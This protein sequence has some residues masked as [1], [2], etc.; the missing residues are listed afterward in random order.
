MLTETKY[1]FPLGRAFSEVEES[2]VGSIKPFGL[3]YAVQ[4]AETVEVDLSTLSYDEE[5][6]I[7]VVSGDGVVVPAMKHTSTKTKTHTG[8][9]RG[10]DSDEDST[11]T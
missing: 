4:P 1:L 11:G 8:D 10:G 2:P 7:A 6:Q 3:R 5:Q 9:N